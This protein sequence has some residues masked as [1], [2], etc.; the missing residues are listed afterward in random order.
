MCEDIMC[1]IFLLRLCIRMF[2][3]HGI[4]EIQRFFL[5]GYTGTKNPRIRPRIK[6]YLRSRSV[7]GNIFGSEKHFK[8]ISSKKNF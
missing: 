3:P 5:Y 6:L 7:L 4:I 2:S 1:S 8:I